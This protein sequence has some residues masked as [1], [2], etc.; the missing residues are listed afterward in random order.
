MDNN[1]N[2]TATITKGLVSIDAVHKLMANLGKDWLHLAIAS[3]RARCVIITT[4]DVFLGVQCMFEEHRVKA[5]A[6][7]EFAVHSFTGIPVEAYGS[8]E[9]AK[10]AAIVARD[11][12]KNPIL[13][14]LEDQA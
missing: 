6:P 10:A 12:G 5:D 7:Y 11:K 13:F 8:P 3:E 1:T 2:T 14:L 9:V 4:H